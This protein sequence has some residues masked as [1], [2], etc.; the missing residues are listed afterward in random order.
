MNEPTATMIARTTLTAIPSA[1][2][3]RRGCAWV[4][5]VVS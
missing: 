5:A 4:T 1:D 2:L 3:S